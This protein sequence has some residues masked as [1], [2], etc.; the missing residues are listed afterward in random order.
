MCN[1]MFCYIC[2]CISI[3]VTTSDEL[4]NSLMPVG[5][6]MFRHEED[7]LSIVANC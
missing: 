7:E 1:Q 4:D 5:K 3:K 6:K 2:I